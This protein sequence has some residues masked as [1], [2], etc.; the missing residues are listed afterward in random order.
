M[1]ESEAVAQSNAELLRVGYE[2]FV[3]GDVPAVLAIFAPDITFKI[4]GRN[5]VAG[6][7]TGHDEVVGFFQK[8][9][10]GSNGTFTITVHDIIDNGDETVVALVNHLAQRDDVKLDT[11]AVHVWQVHD[12]M[13]TSHVSY[14]FDVHAWDAFWS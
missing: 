4:T 11:P 10:E 12:G 7:Y 2:N 1:T 6:E 13:C 5:P 8:L 9:G 14:V 3:A